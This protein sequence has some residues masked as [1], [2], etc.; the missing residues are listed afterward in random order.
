MIIGEPDSSNESARA[1]NVYAI[2]ELMEM[3]LARIIQTCKLEQVQR[4]YIAMQILAGLDYIHESQL[5][6]R[7]I[8]P[9]NILLNKSCETK[10]CDFGLVRLASEFKNHE[11]ST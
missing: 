2:F 9:S 5:I 10:I 11:K 8:K 7:D 4:K 1:K 6:H 3:D